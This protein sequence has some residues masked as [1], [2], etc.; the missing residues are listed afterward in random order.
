[1]RNELK[2]SKAALNLLEVDEP[3][4]CNKAEGIRKNR[5]ELDEALRDLTSKAK[6]EQ[7]VV[8][9]TRRSKPNKPKF[10]T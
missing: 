6:L 10:K 5:K 1:M 3:S 8:K 2:S 9:L 7:E 4:L